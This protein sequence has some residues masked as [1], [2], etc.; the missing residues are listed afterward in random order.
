MRLRLACAL[1]LT[2]AAVPAQNLI[3]AKAGLVHY[4][5]G[6]VLVAGKPLEKKLSL[7][8]TVRPGELLTT[9]EGRAELLLGPG[10]FL[11][12][13]ENSVVRMVNAELTDTRVE[14]VAGAA[15]VEAADT[16]KENHTSITVGQ[17]TAILKREGIYSFQVEPAAIKVWD[18]EA[19]LTHDG[20]TSTV[21][22]GREV[23]LASGEVTKVDR[24]ETDPLY[25]WAKRRSG[26]I[27]LAN[28]SGARRAE[29]WG[30]PASGYAGWY[31]NPWFNMFTFIPARGIWN[32]PFGY[33][34]FSPGAVV[35]LYQP[36][37]A[38]VGGGNRID[39]LGRSVPGWNSD[40]GYSTVPSRSTYGV[41]P[42]GNYGG[43]YGGS[44]GGAA[45]GGGGSVGS[46]RGAAGGGA[47]GSSGGGRGGQ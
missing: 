24:D 36:G 42:G 22:G 17:S 21:K 38:A 1:A 20:K 40:L 45:S 47:A 34:F 7:F 10:V 44:A 14:L 32:S 28:V 3:S 9:G 46:A 18:G 41:E 19:V 27:A 37:F 23:A 16:I 15:I 26:Y 25:R 5:E 31:F 43:G 6:D 11:R 4:A 33:R 2:A 35:Y 39:N 13:A 29:Q 12:V 8:T 30:I